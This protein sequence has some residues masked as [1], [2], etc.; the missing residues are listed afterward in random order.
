MKTLKL[1]S[2]VA[3]LLLASCAGTRCYPVTPVAKKAQ[4]VQAQ[5]INRQFRNQ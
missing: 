3:V 1:L 2:I 4:K 5:N